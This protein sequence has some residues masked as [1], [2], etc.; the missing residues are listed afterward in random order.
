[1]IADLILVFLQNILIDII[2]DYAENNAEIR[3]CRRLIAFLRVIDLFH[4]HTQQRIENVMQY[5]FD[6]CSFGKR[7]FHLFD[8]SRVTLHML[9]IR[10]LLK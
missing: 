5:C 8:Q 3:F 1:M 6:I 2:F 10:I 9:G 4:G 7:R